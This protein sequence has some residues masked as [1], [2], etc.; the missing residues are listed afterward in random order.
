MFIG[1]EKLFL[2]EIEERVAER[3]RVTYVLSWG[4][5]NCRQSCSVHSNLEM[6]AECLTKNFQLAIFNIYHVFAPF[7]KLRGCRFLY[8]FCLCDI[9]HEVVFLIL[10]HFSSRGLKRKKHEILAFKPLLYEIWLKNMTIRKIFWS[11]NI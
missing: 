9:R 1:F 6:E 4:I 8:F 5:S 11:S 10:E 7:V 3:G 2:I